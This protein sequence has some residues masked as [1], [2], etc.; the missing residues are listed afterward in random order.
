MSL[1]DRITQQ[2]ILRERAAA[3][4]KRL[5]D[6]QRANQDAQRKQEQEQNQEEI[7]RLQ[8]EQKELERQIAEF[9]EYERNPDLYREK[10]LADLNKSLSEK[11]DPKVAEIESR[12]SVEVNK[13]IQDTV[14]SGGGPEKW[15]EAARL[16]AKP[17]DQEIENLRRQQNQE[18]NLAVYS[19]EYPGRPL[20][21]SVYRTFKAEGGQVSLVALQQR[22][23]E[24]AE[25]R[26]QYNIQSSITTAKSE[27]AK[28]DQQLEA[29]KIGYESSRE[30]KSTD[31]AVLE[32]LTKESK[33]LK[34]AEGGKYQI[35]NEYKIETRQGN[36]KADPFKD[37][38][39]V[40]A[41]S[42][43]GTTQTRS[44]KAVATFEQTQKEQRELERQIRGASGKAEAD[45]IKSQFQKENPYVGTPNL[46]ER[47]GRTVDT[48]GVTIEKK[49]NTAIKEFETITKTQPS[50]TRIATT[51]ELFEDLNLGESLGGASYTRINQSERADILVEGKDG[52]ARTPTIEE[53]WQITKQNLEL[54]QV[55]FKQS[56]T[57]YELYKYEKEN[58]DAITAFEPVAAKKESLEKQ[59]QKQLN[60]EPKGFE[61][62]I[63]DYIGEQADFAR[64]EIILNPK[65]PEIYERLGFTKERAEKE[66]EKILSK[67]RESLETAVI[68]DIS[69]EIKA[70]VG[71]QPKQESRSIKIIQEK[72]KTQEGQ[73]WL[74]GSIIV[75]TGGTIAA[76]IYAPAAIEAKLATFAERGLIKESKDIAIK[77]SSKA[78]D[79]KFIQQRQNEITNQLIKSNKGLTR[80]EA[81]KLAVSILSKPEEKAMQEAFKKVGLEISEAEARKEIR[82][83]TQTPYTIDVLD[84]KTALITVGSETSDIQRVVLFQRGQKLSKVF[85]APKDRV[86]V[87][88]SILQRGGYSDRADLAKAIKEK[89]PNITKEQLQEQLMKISKDL[90]QGKIVS[91][92]KQAIQAQKEKPLTQRLK[93]RI[94]VSYDE[95]LTG[96]KGSSSTK[97]STIKT[98]IKGT[99]NPE[100]DK[101]TYTRYKATDKNLKL[102]EDEKEYF[103][104]GTEKLVRTKDL[105]KFPQQVIES[106]EVQD[107]TNIGIIIERKPKS[108]ITITSKQSKQSRPYTKP[109]SYTEGEF[110]LTETKADK[111]EI[112]S[113]KQQT[114]MTTESNKMKRDFGK[115]PDAAKE[116]YKPTKSY[117][118]QIRGAATA[119]LNAAGFTQ[120]SYSA[121]QT[122]Q[123]QRTSQRS[124]IQIVQGQSLKTDLVN[125]QKLLPDTKQADLIKEGINQG[126]R[127]NTRQDAAGRFSLISDAAL[128]ESELNALKIKITT[129]QKQKE[130]FDIPDPTIPRNP[131]I[132]IIQTR[133]PPPK[134]FIQARPK[135]TKTTKPPKAGKL[136]FR[137]NV[138]ELSPGYYLPTKE[139]TTSKTTKAISKVERIQTKESKRK[140]RF[141]LY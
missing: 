125:I 40:T 49:L 8:A 39:D 124:D 54:S 53:A 33:N 141:N 123:E 127:T 113:S 117:S 20:Q 104:I 98:T 63:S 120:R 82:V 24:A 10:Q 61:K 134:P 57:D 136:Y 46:L 35:T 42:I 91:T 27:K 16:T 36:L 47:K 62:G 65:T 19:I 111:I 67:P 110:K 97:K 17:F 105:R 96:I 133:Q 45:K 2:Q 130:I 94:M 115:I 88:K 26:R 109:T 15:K 12:K 7:K 99:R 101:I 114:T 60:P 5:K 137:W 80:P 119:S 122:K 95:A 23:D 48:Q 84:S 75:G 25:A 70:G 78:R 89:N 56:K 93:E 87:I 128:K 106:I 44:E 72:S 135:Q 37:L 30:Q 31:A 100:F 118:K 13:I 107:P 14:R 140:I 103:T 121:Q 90:E 18:Y 3:E 66:R 76:S 41:E 81:E 6:Q 1:A 69:N 102:I 71:I 32:K 138:N 4:N 83:R 68:S 112:K 132:K 64:S 92:R 73:L 74:A 50:K 58:L 126:F 22:R 116:S 21:G 86:T 55:D 52:Q 108:K 131:R 85:E 129:R 139:L 59:L 77:I 29:L 43:Y 11:Y 34:S 38:P 9:E 51:I 28:F 79:E